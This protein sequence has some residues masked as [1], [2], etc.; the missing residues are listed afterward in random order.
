MFEIWNMRCFMVAKLNSWRVL[1]YWLK[2]AVD[3]Y[4]SYNAAIVVHSN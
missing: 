3:G 4:L 1:F 2:H